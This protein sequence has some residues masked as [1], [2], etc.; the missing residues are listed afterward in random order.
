MRN[1]NR[2]IAALATLSLLTPLAGALAAPAKSPAKGAPRGILKK[3]TDDLLARV[4]NTRRGS[5]E[6]TRVIVSAA[7]GQDG[8]SAADVLRGAGAHVSDELDS[9]GLVVADVPV[10]RLAELAARE[11]VSWVSSDQDVR[12]T[13]VDNT[14]HH[15]VAT[16]ASKLLPSG[17]EALANGGG[18]NKVGVAI[19]DSGISPPDAAEFAG[20]EWRM[21]SGTLGLGLL[22]QKYLASYPRILKHVD[23]TGEGR[24]DDVYGHGT[25]TAGVAAGTGQASETYAASNAGAQTY[26]GIATNANLLD[27]RVLDSN[28][29]GKVSNVVKAVDW[30]IQNRKTYN[31]RVMNLSLGAPPTQSYKT[32]PLCLALS[33]AVDAGIVVV[34]AAGN[35]GKDSLGRTIYGGILS[36][37]NSPRV[38][39]VGA[40]NTQQTAQRSDDVVATY[41]SRG[42]TLVDGVMKPDLVAPGNKL[43]AA[44]TAS[45]SPTASNNYSSSGGGGVLG[46]VLFG[47]TSTNTP[48]ATGTYRVMSG[49]SFAAPAV[50][51][52]VALMMEANPSLTPSMVKA[53]L[54]RT[55]Q[56]LPV[57]EQL[58]A[59][60]K[61]SH[62][63]RVINE[64]AGELNASAAVTVAKA[65]RK[66]A[67]RAAPGDNLITSKN[68]TYSSLGLTSPIAGE[69]MPLNNGVIWVEGVAFNER[70]TLTA[71]FRLP[72]GRTLKDGWVIV[73]GRVLSDGTYLLSDGHTVAPNDIL[74][75]A[76]LMSDGRP[77]GDAILM[78]D[79]IV[80]TD[81]ILMSD[82]I[83]MADKYPFGSAILMGD[84]IVMTDGLRA[85]AAFA[86]EPAWASNLVEPSSMRLK[87]EQVL[88][89][90][91]AALPTSVN[92]L[93]TS[94]PL[95]PKR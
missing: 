80:M 87:E 89:Q 72:D 82:A 79:G 90:G 77:Y 58:V 57:Y 53:L 26:G 31:V 67:N 38:I 11:E 86:N 42:P 85:S 64:G 22:A 14:S 28:G 51:G 91:E 56:R 13:G 29:A 70:L 40:T 66:D 25:H 36:P 39:T 4:N 32:D 94:S 65:V 23:F 71:G 93:A 34:V 35:W 61:M 41:S 9:L 84:G 69:Q 78:G 52:T 3:M 68:T 88:I 20:W 75:T 6:T 33:R 76:I 55:A 18:G 74:G 49:T 16:G 12:S 37:A 45:T 62:F 30:V 95:Y 50:A 19:L 7:E 92:R 81:A 59:D 1:R 63:E 46:N 27:V 83:L 17:N 47:S 54:M 44:E 24:V 10:E 60:G 48:D 21:S 73:S 43:G 5:G 2:L 15:E 8:A